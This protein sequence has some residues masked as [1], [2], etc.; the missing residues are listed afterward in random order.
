MTES[1]RIVLADDERPARR[2]LRNL[3]ESFPEVSVV[4]EAATGHE[5]L[6]LIEQA[7]PHLV[8][9][10]LH[11]PELG[12]LDTARLLTQEA[13][14][15]IAFVTA[16]D[17]FAV[18]A[19]ELNAVDYLLKPVERDRLAETLQRARHRVSGAERSRRVSAAVAAMEI[20]ARRPYL[21]RL[22][23]RRRDEMVILPVRQIASIV[24][25]GELM[26]ITTVTAERFTISHRLHLL[27]ARLDPRRFVRLSRSALAALDQIQR[28]S[29]M[30]GGTY[31]VTLANGQALQV[32]RIQSR[33]LRETLLTL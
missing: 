25:D 8:L 33:R 27:E 15:L 26:H 13:P 30:P 16:H 14:P 18:E 3:L 4:G 20:A 22:P 32:S 9:L 1:L 29:P 21:E 24:A 10:D 6:A 12:G 2:F 17:E 19:F 23:V 11:M 28:V 5:A 31:Q 7:S